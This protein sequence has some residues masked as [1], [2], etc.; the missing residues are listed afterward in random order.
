MEG[1]KLLYDCS[2]TRGRGE[3][4]L[5]GVA[6]VLVC[7]GGARYLSPRI[8]V[9][10]TSVPGLYAGD[11]ASHGLAVVSRPQLVPGSTH[12]SGRVM[13]LWH[14]FVR[15]LYLVRRSDT[16]DT[17]HQMSLFKW[18]LQRLTDSVIT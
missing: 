7:D 12:W 10:F 13:S 5:L 9:L 2:V 16:T 4:P 18:L 8:A 6:S 3:I 11:S 15:S 14:D 17:M 1:M